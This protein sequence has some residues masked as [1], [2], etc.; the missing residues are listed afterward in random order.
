M[1]DMAANVRIRGSGFAPTAR[2]PTQPGFLELWSWGL[3]GHLSGH[4]SPAGLRPG[5]TRGAGEGQ[6]RF[7]T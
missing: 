3:N 5:T 6:A 2:P 7:R 4:S 1:W